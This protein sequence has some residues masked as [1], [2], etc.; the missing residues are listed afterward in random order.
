[1][2]GLSVACTWRWGSA[3]EVHAGLL[4]LYRSKGLDWLP[5]LTFFSQWKKLFLAAE[6]PLG[7]EWCQLEGWDDASNMQLSSFSFCV[8]KSGFLPTVLLKFLKWSLLELF[9]FV[10][11]CL[12]LIF[13]RR[14][15]LGFPTPPSQ[16]CHPCLVEKWDNSCQ[17]FT[18]CLA[19]GKFSERL[20]PISIPIANAL[21]LDLAKHSWAILRDLPNSY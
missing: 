11:T 14:W 3:V 18:K 16:W 20:V 13:V 7:T 15:S 4:H 12:M 6:F 1:M 21:S 9:L 2:E 10:V 19:N 5:V 17:Y 8:V